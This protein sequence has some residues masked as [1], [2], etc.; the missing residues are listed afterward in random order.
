MN[1]QANAYLKNRVMSASPE[2]LR[3]MLFE[4]AIRFSRQAKT[5]IEQQDYEQMF[6][7]VS[8]AQAILLEL[9]SNLKPEHHPELCVN[10][11]ALYTY[12]YRRLIDANSEHDVAIIDEVIMH[13]EYE[14]DSW[15]LLMG[16]LETHYGTTQSPVLVSS[17]THNSVE[18]QDAP[19]SR[20]SISVQG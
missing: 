19:E 4:G 18:V 7:G 9:I 20:P 15:K 17:D 2:E 3:L 1:E 16:Q 12:L 6:L 14:R 10:L 8:Q 11:S 13:L 5:G